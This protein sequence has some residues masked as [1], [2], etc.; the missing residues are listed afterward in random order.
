MTHRFAGILSCNCAVGV[1]MCCASLGGGVLVVVVH[2]DC[3]Y[4]V[5]VRATLRACIKLGRPSRE[6][7]DPP[8]NTQLRLTQIDPSPLTSRSQQNQ[9]QLR[10]QCATHLAVV[11]TDVFIMKRLPKLHC[12]RVHETSIAADR[13]QSMETDVS[14]STN[15]STLTDSMSGDLHCN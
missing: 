11:N 13:A 14:Q 12:C 6:S 7:A 2:A 9:D 15:C 10:S 4:D 1:Q 5:S 3:R 8:Q